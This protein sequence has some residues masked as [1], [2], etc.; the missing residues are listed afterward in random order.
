MFR[1][2]A[3]MC[4]FA[5]TGF[6]L[7]AAPAGASY[8]Y[9]LAYSHSTSG[10]SG[11]SN[12]F[13]GTSLEDFNHV[14]IDYDN[15]GIADVVTDIDRGQ[16]TGSLTGT[17]GAKV[18]SDYPL[19]LTYVYRWSDH[20]A[21]EDGGLR[22]T[23][24]PERSVGDEYYIPLATN[25]GSILAIVDSTTI[26][27][28]DDN[29]GI[30]DS[31]LNLNA[32]QNMFL[33]FSAGAHVW[34]DQNFY[35]VA[36]N[37]LNPPEDST[38]AY[39]VFPLNSYGDHY[40]VPNQ[41]GYNLNSSTDF[42]GVH[43]VSAQDGI[44][45]N[46]GI[47]Q[48]ILDAGDVWFF[49][50]ATEREIT[51]DGPVFA[52]YLSTI[53]ATD[54]WRSVVRKYDFAYP[55][56]PFLFK[57]NGFYTS[58][59]DISV[60]GGPKTQLFIASHTNGNQIDLD[61]NEDGVDHTVTLDAGETFYL[62]ET[63]AIVTC[64]RTNLTRVNSSAPMHAS[65]SFR[66][67]WSNLSETTDAFPYSVR[68]CNCE[69]DADCNDGD[70]CNGT[71][72]CVDSCSCE[73]GEDPCPDD[74]LYCTGDES[75]DE[76]NDLCEASGDP[77]EQ[78]AAFC[79][80]VETCDEDADSCVSPGDPCAAGDGDFCN[81]DEH[82]DETNDQCVSSGDPCED[83][84]GIW[85]NGD[86]YCDEDADQCASTGDPCPPGEECEEDADQCI[87]I[88]VPPG[89]DDDDTD[90]NSGDDGDETLWPEGKVTGGCCGC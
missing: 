6:L 3:L 33:G 36:A 48:Q 62:H 79:N 70:F 12:A 19:Q 76:T 27:V 77:C 30:A 15:D 82:C 43:I 38:F 56:M 66:G 65:I 88:D 69:V 75:C 41:H 35:V 34:G 73:P 2:I 22:Y 67:W 89:G 61:C 74:G 59:G 1:R 26:W 28:D 60:Q 10:P 58:G 49:P 24:L 7:L 18:V 68:A 72:T 21:Y 90:P 4:V 71:E 85:C 51:A 50:T 54:P 16:G 63:S 57:V 55:L 86:E 44:T 83:D 53:S 13:S 5:A 9:W 45:V 46:I 29:D 20:G 14:E 84:D 78:D 17:T 25:D 81:G 31:T 52:V 42:S 80:G 23:L 11:T 40:M 64:W 87:F 39:S 32:G 37:H 47:N 8:T